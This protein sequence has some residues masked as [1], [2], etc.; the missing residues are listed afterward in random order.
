MSINSHSLIL[1]WGSDLNTRKS[2]ALNYFSEHQILDMHQIRKELT[3]D[4]HTLMSRYQIKQELVHRVGLRLGLGQQ[5]VLNLDDATH[6]DVAHWSSVCENVGAQLCVVLFDQ[7]LTT[8]KAQLIRAE[9]FSHTCPSITKVLAVGDVHGDFD[10]MKAAW[11]YA[12]ANQM[13]VVWLGDVVDYGDHN[14]KCVHLAYQSV[15]SGNAHMIWGN[16]ERKIG[17]W[18][19][20]N[21]G[22]YYRGRLSDANWKTIREIESLAPHRQKRFVAA[23]KFL[24]HNSTQTLQL[25]DW[26]FTHGAIHTDAW[27]YAGTRRLPGVAGEWAYFGEVH[28]PMF[29]TD[30]YPHR[31]WDWVEQLPEH[32]RVVVG[33]DWIDREAMKVTVKIGSQGAQVWCV[34][35]GS[36]KGGQLSAL[37]IDLH[38]N[39]WEAKVFTP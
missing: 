19:D 36:S 26:M 2:W 21:L 11:D 24:E 3:G 32:A 27:Q 4:A 16:H 25:G 33:H 9:D 17:K 22:E 1:L 30:G 23:W 14:L 12:Q 37:H 39:D 13:F 8:S 31:V 6:L 28:S 34:D 5:V 10:A 35:T 15:S 18:V 20:A 7:K 38:T 29:N